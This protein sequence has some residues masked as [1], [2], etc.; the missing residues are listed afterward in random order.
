MGLELYARIEPLLGFETSVEALYAHYFEILESWRPRRLIDIGCGNGRFLKEATRRFELTRAYGVDLSEEM[1]ARARAEGV[2]ADARDLCD[3]TEVFDTA[4][5]VFDVLNYLPADA[6]PG[7]FS[8]VGAVLEP[9]GLF[10]ADCNTEVGFE[11]VAP[12]ALI[13]RGRDFYLG[14]DAIYEPPILRTRIDYFHWEEGACRH[15]KDTV[16]QYYHPTERLARVCGPLELIQAHPVQMY[17]EDPDKEI[18][19][20][21]KPA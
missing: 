5:A 14:I 19:L 20:F 15:E 11:E 16:V 7:F 2:E 6:L 13:R 3:V 17:G 10:V 9:G 8:C 4:T 1:V 12:G 21:R 18:L